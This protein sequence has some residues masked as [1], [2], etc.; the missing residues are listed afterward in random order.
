MGVDVPERAEQVLRAAAAEARSRGAVLHVLHAW[1]FP[2]YEDITVP[3]TESEE[4]AAR[5]TAEIQTALDTLGDDRRGG[6]VRIEARHA[7]LPTRSSRPA[8]RPSC[9]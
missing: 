8:R 1:S 4:W 3:R 5:A 7:S 9:W 6:P 2:T